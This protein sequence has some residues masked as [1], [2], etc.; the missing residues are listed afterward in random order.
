[1][2]AVAHEKALTEQTIKSAFR[3]TGVVPFNPD[4]ITEEMMAPSTS[5][6]TN[7]TLPL[8]QAS[9]IRA[10]TDMLHQCIARQAMDVAEEDRPSQLDDMPND[11]PTTP[12]RVAA[13]ALESTSASFLMSGSPLKSTSR[14]PPFRP[15]TISPFKQSRY[16]DL[17]DKP[18]M[19]AREQELQNA[20]IESES[21]DSNR[22]HAMISMQAG[23]VL[24]DLYVAQARE[25]L[26]EHEQRKKKKKSNRLF[27]DGLPKLLDDDVFFNK[28]TEHEA[29]KKRKADAKEDRRLLR[30]AHATSLAEWKKQE[31]ERKE[32]N[33]ET[34]LVYQQAVQAWEAER[35]LAKLQ[36]R[37]AGWTKPKQGI[38]LK[39]LPRPVREQIASSGSEGEEEFGDDDV[40][41]DAGDA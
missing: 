38:I 3:S 4:A 29:E 23:V 19:T 5:T 15:F 37:K 7:A 27:G 18:P 34:R 41:S 16:H 17:L 11:Q 26:E 20:L 1:V 8:P 2:Y 25:Q 21:R 33:K 14:L 35:D 22:K 28:V 30:E 9:P 31:D 39:P 13:N 6:S 12:V 24:Q 32:K 10:V 36:H 40:G